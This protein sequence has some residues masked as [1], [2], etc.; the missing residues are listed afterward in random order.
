VGKS[1]NSARSIKK[2]KNTKL[3]HLFES[4]LSMLLGQE[5]VEVLSFSVWLL[6]LIQ[7]SKINNNKQKRIHT[8]T[9]NLRQINGFI[10]V[11]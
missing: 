2:I 6:L 8:I 9:F 4:G 10:V 3:Y 1:S 11:T 7:S 5:I